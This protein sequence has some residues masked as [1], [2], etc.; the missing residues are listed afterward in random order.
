M[1]YILPFLILLTVACAS[2]KEERKVQEWKGSVTI[3][4]PTQDGRI[5]P[6]PVPFRVSGDEIT[7]SE[8]KTSVDNE[9]IQ[10]AVATAVQTAMGSVPGSNWLQMLG[11][12]GGVATVATTGYLALKKREQLKRGK[13][14]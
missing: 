8:T 9:A 7:T 12:V 1:R 13:D 3:P 5:V 14:S 4:V 2:R 10:T 11:G 6:T